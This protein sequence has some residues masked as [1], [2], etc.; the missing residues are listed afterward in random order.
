M[1]CVAMEDL[2]YGW[3]IV[4]TCN[5]VALMTGGTGANVEEAYR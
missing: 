2:Y 1:V 5:F 3:Y 4:A